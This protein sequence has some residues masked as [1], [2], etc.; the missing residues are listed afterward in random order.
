MRHLDPRLSRL[1][2][3]RKVAEARA[4][5]RTRVLTE[6]QKVRRLWPRIGALL[7]SA[8]ERLAKKKTEL[9]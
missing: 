1:L 4:R 6:R 9:A 2:A 8:G 3:E 7:I 5:P